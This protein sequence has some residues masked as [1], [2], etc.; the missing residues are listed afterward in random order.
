M[1]GEGTDIKPISTIVKADLVRAHSKTMQQVFRGMRYC[2]EWDEEANLCDIYLA[3]DSELVE[4]LDRI[5]S[6]QQIGVTRKKERESGA[7][8]EGSN[9]QEASP[10]ELK[11]VTHR[12][13][14]THSVD[15]YHKTPP[16][17]GAR[18]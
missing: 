7:M 15:F 14:K 2:S 1:I 8:S 13:L 4:T 18:G 11:D 6:E 16:K 17:Q 3:N 9:P 12:R 10:W 5:T